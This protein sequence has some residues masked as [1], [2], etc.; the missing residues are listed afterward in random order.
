MVE[1]QWDGKEVIFTSDEKD[2]ATGITKTL[3]KR[4]ASV[5]GFIKINPLVSTRVAPLK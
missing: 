1:G 5:E 2:L 3:Q 4:L